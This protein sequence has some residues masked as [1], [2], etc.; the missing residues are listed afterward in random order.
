MTSENF[1]TSNFHVGWKVIEEVDENESHF[2]RD[3]CAG[4]LR[5]GRLIFNNH[6]CPFSRVTTIIRVVSS[7]YTLNSVFFCHTK[8]T[9]ALILWGV[10]LISS[11]GAM[12]VKAMIKSRAE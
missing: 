1:P 10:T 4:V 5:L 2:L 3:L 7:W 11:L 8:S 9:A 6:E 12:L